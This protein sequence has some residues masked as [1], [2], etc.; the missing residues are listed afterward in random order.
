MSAA[1]T[2]GASAPAAPSFEVLEDVSAAIESGAGL[3]A[4]AR[5]TARALGAGVAVLDASSNVLAVAGT[6]PQ[7]ERGLLAGKSGTVIH[8]LTLADAKVGE[9]RLRPRQAAPDSALVRMVGALIALEVDRSRA[10]ERAT[11]AAVGTFLADLLDRRVTDRD[12]I[13]ARGRELGADLGAGASVLVVRAHARQ[14]EEGDWRGRVLGVAEQ[15]A[16]SVA[17]GA[18]GAAIEQIAGRRRPG[19][20]RPAGAEPKRAARADAAGGHDGE[21]VVVVPGDQ[22]GAHRAG[23]AIL[24]ELDARYPQHAFSIARSRLATDPIDLHRA[25]VEALLAANVADARGL[26]QLA[27]EETG[28]YRLLLPA[29]SEDAAELQRFHDE[30]VAPLLRYD[31]QYETELTRTLETFLDANGSVANT[32]QTLFTHRHTVR[33]RLERVR[34]LTGLDVSSTEGRERL[35]L[36]LKAMRVLGIQPHRGPASERGAEG[37]QVPRDEHDR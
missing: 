35:G 15:S 36:G 9:L 8:D 24:R 19:T 11:E 33:Y 1:R 4:V 13:V 32:S 7:D 25:G 28:A 12:N 18:L 37:G 10:P 3:P 6:T 20:E 23:E 27:F 30:T 21:L 17:G 14:P 31:E 34:E 2:S 29:L 16:R 22:E 5:A 26:D